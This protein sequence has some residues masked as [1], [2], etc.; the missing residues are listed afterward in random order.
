MWGFSLQFWQ[1]VFIWAT[2]VT[3]VSGTVAV[4]A[5]FVST[6]VGYKISGVVQADADRRIAEAGATAATANAE[7]AKAKEAAAKAHERA[8]GLE[9]EAAEARV[10][11]ER[12]RAEIA[13]RRL[14]KEQ[15][16]SIVAGLKGQT[17]EV[18]VGTVGDNPEAE[19]YWEDIVRTLKDAGLDVTS[20][21]AWAR[22][23]GM[24]I[25]PPLGPERDALKAA[26][27][28][29]ELSFGMQKKDRMGSGNYRRQQA[30]AVLA[31]PEALTLG[32]FFRRTLNMVLSRSVCGIPKMAMRCSSA[33]CLEA[34]LRSRMIPP[35]LASDTGPNPTMQSE[36]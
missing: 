10:E 3:V 33:S 29:A 14:S 16:D 22:S 18:W 12:I 13:W 27:A 23:I 9:K 35:I 7:A 36:N 31:T 24:A 5:A 2:I 1:S 28:A 34:F 30:S 11:Q 15:Y 19:G 21:R 20:H 17:F 6:W 32:F 8:A 26:F 4:T 25:T